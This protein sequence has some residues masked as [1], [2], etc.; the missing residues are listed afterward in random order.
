MP[1]EAVQRMALESRQ[2]LAQ[3]AAEVCLTPR[4][5]NDRRWPD[6][7][8][9]DRLGE[10]IEL[11]AGGGPVILVTGHLGNWE[12]LGYFLATLGFPSEVLARPLDNRLINDWLLGIRQRR[13]LRIL[14]KWDA[15]ERMQQI[16][17]RGGALGFTADQDAGQKGVFVPFLGRLASAYKSIGLLALHH[18]CPV[19]CGYAHRV[20]DGGREGRAKP[21]A[22]SGAGPRYRVGL[23][24]V[25]RPGDWAEMEDPLYYVTARYTRALEAAVRLKPEQYLWTYRRWKSRPRHERRGQAMPGGLRRQ[26]LGLPW[27][28]EAGVE[29]LVEAGKREPLDAE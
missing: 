17:D 24:D 14:T 26:L 1:P 4:L 27:M 10:G 5:I 12:L 28:D 11:M 19:V 6:R 25:I 20:A 9:L 13:G 18:G 29:A 3:L 23:T 2:H 22:A 8:E 7:V 21:Q 15:S 16:L